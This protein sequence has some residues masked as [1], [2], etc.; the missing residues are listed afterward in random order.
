MCYM[1]RPH[2]HTPGSIGE[3]GSPGKM[4]QHC[5]LGDFG[6]SV[7]QQSVPRLPESG[8]RFTSLDLHQALSLSELTPLVH[9]VGMMSTSGFQRCGWNTA[10]RI[11]FVHL[12][13][14]RTGAVIVVR[15]KNGYLE[16]GPRRRSALPGVQREPEGTEMGAQG[17][18]PSS[19]SAC[20]PRGGLQPASAS[21]TLCSAVTYQAS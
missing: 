8:M 3:H 14:K 4:S 9:S 19:R 2:T 15:K 6:G 1:S 10:H 17:A 12:Q 13:P 5:I 16:T 7:L 18:Q 20:P 11:T 21:L